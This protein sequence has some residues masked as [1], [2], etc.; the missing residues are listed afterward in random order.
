MSVPTLPVTYQSHNFNKDQK[1]RLD[2]LISEGLVVMDEVKALQEGLNDTVSSVAEELELKPS[3]LK[4][5]I[6]I[7]FQN[8]F[9][10][11]E[12]DHLTLEEILKTVGRA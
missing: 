6:K 5:A 8:N 1:D 10:D 2:K 12:N 4:K 9:S 7:A 3:I 11:A